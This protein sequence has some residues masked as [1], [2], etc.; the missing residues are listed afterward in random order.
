MAIL[1]NIFKEEKTST[2]IQSIFSFQN[3]GNRETGKT[4]QAG[5]Q[6]DTGTEKAGKECRVLLLVQQRSGTCT[7]TVGYK[8]K[9]SIPTTS[10]YSQGRRHYRGLRRYREWCRYRGWCRY[11]GRC[12]H[13]G[14]F[15][16]RMWCHHYDTVRRTRCNINA[17]IQTTA[18]SKD[19]GENK[20]NSMFLVALL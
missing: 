17:H 1:F 2:F 3:D 8:P 12:P 5:S 9:V 20:E 6:V 15:Y 4:N 16:H 11:S 7:F 18:T 10:G 14:R 19:N 13:C